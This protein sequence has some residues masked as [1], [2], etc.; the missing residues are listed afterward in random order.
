MF[1]AWTFFFIG[2]F[3]NPEKFKEALRKKKDKK[4]KKKNQLVIS[5]E[6]RGD[7]SKRTTL[8]DVLSIS[9]S[10]PLL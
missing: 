8:N 6:E 9:K 7:E 4:K 1:V 3:K 2:Y 5:D 10:E